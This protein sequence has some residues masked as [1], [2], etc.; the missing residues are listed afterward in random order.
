MAASNDWQ[1][2]K[3][4]PTDLC[5]PPEGGQCH[6]ATA[7]C[8]A[9]PGAGTTSMSHS[10]PEALL[11]LLGLISPEYRSQWLY[12][13]LLTENHKPDLLT[14]LHQATHK[15]PFVEKSRVSLKE[16]GRKLF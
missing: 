8:L 16:V 2:T 13:N 11:A 6:T 5:L 14:H 4:H 7:E 15:S 10:R 12:A 3:N 1:C 9:T